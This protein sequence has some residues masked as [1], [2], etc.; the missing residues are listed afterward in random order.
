MIPSHT[1]SPSLTEQN[2]SL[3]R[4]RED[5]TAPPDAI[6]IGEGCEEERRDMEI[7]NGREDLDETMNEIF[8]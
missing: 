6:Q 2:Q 3:Y 1:S 7:S 4:G 5:I 8:G